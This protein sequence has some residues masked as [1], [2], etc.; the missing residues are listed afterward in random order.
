M[1]L[2]YLDTD[3]VG[4]KM[5]EV[6][7]NFSVELDGRFS[8]IRTSETNLGNFICDILMASCNGDVALL[9]SGTLRSDRIHPRGDFKMRDLMTILPML[10]PLLVLEI[11]GNPLITDAASRHDGLISGM[12]AWLSY[13]N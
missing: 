11:T 1:S 6:L 10:D 13:T 12:N 5:D 8:S 9:N 7:G 2:V 3:V 4:K